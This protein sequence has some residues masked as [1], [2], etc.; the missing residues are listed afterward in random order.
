L[1]CQA[2]LSWNYKN[3]KVTTNHELIIP[4]ISS[5]FIKPVLLVA[6]SQHFKFFNSLWVVV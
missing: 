5:G 2:G 4:E 6:I 3:G 1:G